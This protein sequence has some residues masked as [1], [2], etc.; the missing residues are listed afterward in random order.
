M[1]GDR[2]PRVLPDGAPWAPRVSPA[3]LAEFAA[4]RWCAEQA[5]VDLGLQPLPVHV[6]EHREPLWPPGVVGSITH[7]GD[8]RGAAV[9]RSSDVAA[10]GVD[11]ERRHVLSPGVAELVLGPD[12]LGRLARGELDPDLAW[13]VV[14]SVKEAIFK[15]WFAR[16]RVWLDFLDVDLRLAHLH[17]SPGGTTGSFFVRPSAQRSDPGPL[18][19]RHLKCRF[20]LGPA[21]VASVAYLEMPRR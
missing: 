12:E 20:A 18:D 8:Y 15:A 16:T 3:R 14:F 11:V 7:T 6:G 2:R 10:L 13:L 5:M 1:W 9:A 21:V 4:G 17:G 19:L